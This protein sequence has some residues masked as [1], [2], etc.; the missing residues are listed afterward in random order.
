MTH[1]YA[2]NI[3]GLPVDDVLIM[4]KSLVMLVKLS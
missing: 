4:T 1:H 3:S 2:T